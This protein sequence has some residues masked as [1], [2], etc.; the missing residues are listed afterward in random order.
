MDVLSASRRDDRP[1]RLVRGW[2]V[3]IGS[4]FIALMA[5]VVGVLSL[6]G[7]HDDVARSYWERNSPSVLLFVSLGALIIGPVIAAR[8]ARH[9]GFRVALVIPI[10]AL[11]LVGVRIAIA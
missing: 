7:D 8:V 11:F 1:T 3:V 2:F 5:L 4:W 6:I 10:A 9:G